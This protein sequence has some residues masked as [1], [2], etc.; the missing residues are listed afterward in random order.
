MVGKV[1]AVDRWK[2]VID[3]GASDPASSP[4]SESHGGKLA[5]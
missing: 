4:V 5:Q 1:R 3:L 2:V